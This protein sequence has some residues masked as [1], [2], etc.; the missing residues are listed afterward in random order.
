MYVASWA[1]DPAETSATTFQVLSVG[2]YPSTS[3]SYTETFST[4][5]NWSPIQTSSSPFFVKSTTIAPFYSSN[6]AVIVNGA[7]SI[8]ISTD[9]MATSTQWI[10]DPSFSSGTL[11]SPV[12]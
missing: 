5:S 6:N 8:Q 11:T 3:P 7:L 2:A 12:D 10:K 1:T 9:S 4:L